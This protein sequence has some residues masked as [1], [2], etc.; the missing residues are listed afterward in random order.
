MLQEGQNKLS[1]GWYLKIG[2]GHKRDYASLLPPKSNRPARFRKDSDNSI[3]LPPL[4]RPAGIPSL[5]FERNIRQRSENR[6]DSHL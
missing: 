2:K 5:G 3:F 4:P 1:N 6:E